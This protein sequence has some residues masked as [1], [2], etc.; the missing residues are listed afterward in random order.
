MLDVQTGKFKALKRIPMFGSF[1]LKTVTTEVHP[2]RFCELNRLFPI[3]HQPKAE[4]ENVERSP[5]T[6]LATENPQPV[7]FANQNSRLPLGQS[8][9]VE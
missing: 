1:A 4:R 7:A 6:N 5:K 9:S 8:I 3:A 2:P